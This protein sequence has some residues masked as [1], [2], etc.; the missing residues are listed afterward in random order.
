MQIKRNHNTKRRQNRVNMLMCAALAA[1]LGL[2][3]IPASAITS[4]KNSV[5]IRVDTSKLE[6]AEGVIDVYQILS[7]KANKACKTGGRLTL[8]HRRADAICSANLLKDFIV[9]LNGPRVTAYH[10]KMVS[11]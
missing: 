4:S 10:K 5:S 3:A 7:R 6:T 1:G 8:R 2:G 11:Q 9:D